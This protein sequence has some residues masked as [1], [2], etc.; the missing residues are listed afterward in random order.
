MDT[1]ISGNIRN[2]LLY[3]I[4]S[5]YEPGRCGVIAAMGR[6]DPSTQRD[7]PAAFEAY[8]LLLN[9]LDRT[10]LQNAAP[11]APVVELSPGVHCMPCTDGDGEQAASVKGRVVCLVGVEAGMLGYAAHWLVDNLRSDT[12]RR[13]GGILAVPFEIRQIDARDHLVPDWFCIF[14]QSAN[15][16]LNYP[17]LS[18]RSVLTDERFRGEWTDVARARAPLYGLPMHDPMKAP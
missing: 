8:S 18:F 11:G 4:G 13:M 1:G 15:P 17:L 14:Y 5:L 2:M 12:V 3:E 7:I 6:N 10:E 16:R 9:Q